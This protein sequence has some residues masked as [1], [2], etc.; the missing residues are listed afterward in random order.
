MYR[1][2]LITRW[3]YVLNGMVKMGDITQAQADGMKFPPL[4]TDSPAFALQQQSG[5]VNPNDP[6]APYVMNVVQNELEVPASQG[7]DGYTPD[8]LDT[9]G[10][11]IVTTISRS[12]E[13]ALYN[14]VNT[15]VALMAERGGPLPS[16]ARIGGEVQNPQNGEILAIYPGPGYT[17]NQAKCALEDCQVNM[18]VYAR[19][20]VGSSFKPYVLSEAVIQG[21]NA[22]T[23]VLNADSPLW[24]PPHTLG[25][26]LSTTDKTKKAPASYEVTN[27][28]FQNHGGLNA[29]D[30]LAISS[31]TAYSDL[32]HRVGT[33][34][35]INLAEQ[36]GV[37]GKDYLQQYQG[38]VGLALGIGSL[39]VNE[40][41]TMLATIANG[42]VYH[43]AHLISYIINPSGSRLNGKYN[44]HTVMTP[45][46][47]S[48]V[49]WGMSTVV[50]KGTAAGMINMTRPI[51]AKTGTTTSNRSAYFVGAIPQYALTIAIFTKDQA[52]CLD[53]VQPKLGEP[54]LKK[55]P[56]TL[57]KLGG[58]SK[59]GFGGYWP[60]KIWNTY[61]QSQFVN[62]PV[63]QFLQPVFTGSKWIQLVV[64]PT[65]NPSATP[66]ATPTCQ[67]NIPF[68]N[69][70]GGRTKGPGFP[71][72][73]ATSPTA[74]PTCVG[75][76]CTTNP[77]ATPT[78]T[79]PTGLPTGVVPT[80]GTAATTAATRASP[81]VTQSGFAVG[82]LLSVVP[83]SL[84]WVRVSRRKR[85]RTRGDG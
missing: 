30:A 63:Q 79:S 80:A 16:Y 52:A 51:I 76:F 31:N 55:N 43:A 53:K 45:D 10:L 34:N 25:N 82:G 81:A 14:A 60:A 62:L 84:L 23:S 83:G 69:G 70:K 2:N 59:G 1:S 46:Q 85:R 13:I 27:D 36:M 22:Q 12:D 73:P 57:D 11:K 15:N 26:V 4:L 54:C 66:S 37:D 44:Q 18:A 33:Q 6:W 5:I 77:S 39:T 64:P 67:K 7:G 61:A 32:A 68:C 3:H 50:T 72:L 9:G 49:Q 21:M 47:A 74:T 41:D 65:P 78:A 24:V 38:A 8:Q 42:G 40:Q 75:F 71:T 58:T 35:I 20:Q 17:S 28:D 19:A 56:E 48:Q 29:Q